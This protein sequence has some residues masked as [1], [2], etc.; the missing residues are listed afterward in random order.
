[1]GPF[2]SPRKLLGEGHPAAEL[3]SPQ[4]SSPVRPH[5]RQLHPGGPQTHFMLLGPARPFRT[6]LRAAPLLRPA[7]GSAAAR[8]LSLHSC[9][10]KQ[11]FLARVCGVIVGSAPQEGAGGFGRETSLSPPSQPLHTAGPWPAALLF[12]HEPCRKVLFYPQKDGHLYAAGSFAFSQYIEMNCELVLQL[13]GCHRTPKGTEDRPLLNSCSFG[14]LGSETW[15]G[16]TVR[17]AELEV[18]YKSSR[19]KS[20][21]G[22]CLLPGGPF[23]SAK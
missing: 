16:N 4:P 20:G 1:M 14:L 15:K 22:G 19:R 2:C 23:G 5:L 11:S 18:K 12:Q 9:T 8:K 21:D 13:G 7:T 3:Q 6:L 17:N 10:Q